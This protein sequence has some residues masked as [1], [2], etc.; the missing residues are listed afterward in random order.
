[1]AELLAIPGA[2][3]LFGGKEL[4]GHTI[5]KCYGAIEPTAVFVPLNEA[6]KK[7]HFGVVTKEVF[8]PLQAR[9]T[10]EK[11]HRG[12][13]RSEILPS[14]LSSPIAFGQVV[15]EYKTSQLDSV[16]TAMEGM[17]EHLT[18]ES[19]GGLVAAGWSLVSPRAC[20]PLHSRYCLERRRVSQPRH[21][22][23]RERHD[24]RGHPRPHDWRAAE[25]LVRQGYGAGGGE[26][27]R[28]KAAS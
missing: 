15:T 4:Q 2:R 5:P 25:P 24:V 23:H 8:G 27:S 10:R 28:G 18:G 16:L 1:M 17:S 7:K 26:S 12:S 14:S 6:L 11:M 9:Q 22:A 13:M 21:R 3:L 19:G 20:L